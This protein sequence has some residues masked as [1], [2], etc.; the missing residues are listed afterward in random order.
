[1]EDEPMSTTE[2]KNKELAQELP[3]AIINEGNLDLIDE[4][5]TV[6]YV[7][8]HSAIPEPFDRG[9]LKEAITMF[10]TA[11]PDLELQFEDV[12]VDDEKVVRRDR[13]TGTHEGEFMGIEPTGTRVEIPGIDI[14]RFE[15]G[16]VAE[17]WYQADMMGLMLQLGVI[18]PP[19]E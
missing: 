19:G 10:R 15:D 13:A 6:G 4:H 11:F 7:G 16:K 3:Q 5:F 8:R 18:E 12:I 1:M 14:V 9:G 17:E 2:S